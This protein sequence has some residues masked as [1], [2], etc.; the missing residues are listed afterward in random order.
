MHQKYFVRYFCSLL[1]I[2]ATPLKAIDVLPDGVP[3]IGRF[4]ECREIAITLAS[5]VHRCHDLYHGQD[6]IIKAVKQVDHGYFANEIEIFFR[7][8]ISPW[9]INLLETMEN[10]SW[11]YQILEYG[12]GGD[13][14]DLL[15]DHYP[16]GM[17]ETTVQAWFNHIING[18]AHLHENNIAH[19]DV[20]PE[21]F[22]LVH[23]GL[24]WILKIG[25]FG[26]SE[27]LPKGFLPSGIRKGTSHFLAPEAWLDLKAKRYD[28]FKFDTFAAGVMLYAALTDFLPFNKAQFKDRSFKILTTRGVFALMKS[29]GVTKSFSPEV[30]DLLEQMLCPEPKRRA[31]INQ[32]L[33]HPWLKMKTFKPVKKLKKKKRNKQSLR[34]ELYPIVG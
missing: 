14:F 25:D 3:N 6:V 4:T 27:Y 19:L 21:N 8:G 5:K 31:T 11:C 30:I 16:G 15:H 9:G 22:F 26:L 32:V 1:L 17:P 23:N 2:L 33:A 24:S 29:Q 34:A 18:L 20:K 10:D 13:F 12:Q 28:P 7:A